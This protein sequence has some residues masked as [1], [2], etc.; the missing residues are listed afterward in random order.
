MVF[1]LATAV[2][3]DQAGEIGDCRGH[4]VLQ[5]DN[6]THGCARDA[7]R[8]EVVAYRIDELSLLGETQERE[9]EEGDEGEEQDRRWHAE[10]EAAA[11]P[12]DAG[13]AGGHIHDIERD[14]GVAGEAVGERGHPQSGEQSGNL[15][16]CDEHA[17]CHADGEGEQVSQCQGERDRNAAI[18]QVEHPCGRHRIDGDDR[19][20][21]AAPDD[22]NRHTDTENT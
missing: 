18:R 16:I 20:V 7:R 13:G 21:D 1:M 11:N 3:R 9:A 2:A 15:E 22:D 4:R 12:R 19:K 5:D 17:V 8:R 6:W 14:E 10:D